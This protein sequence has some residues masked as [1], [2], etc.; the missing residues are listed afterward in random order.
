MKRRSGVVSAS[1]YTCVKRLRNERG[2]FLRPPPSLTGFWHAKNLVNLCCTLNVIASSGM[3]T[4]ERWSKQA[5]NPSSTD[6]HARFNCTHNS[7]NINKATADHTSPTLCT[8]ITLFPADPICSECGATERSLL[9]HDVTGGWMTPFA[10]N[11]LQCIVNGEEN[12]QNCPFPLGIRHP[13][14]EGGGPSHHHRQ[15]T[16]KNW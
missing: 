14:P 1:M 8:P 16:Q 10:A 9:L 12:S 7:N 6:W 3:K 15:H 5:F 11:V 13:D 4:S 2:K